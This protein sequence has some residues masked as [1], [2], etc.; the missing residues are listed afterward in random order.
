MMRD[1]DQL[2]STNVRAALAGCPF[3]TEIIYRPC[4]GS[5]NDLA[6]EKASAGVPEGL[7]VIADQQTAGRGRLGRRW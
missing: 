5:T 2:T 3:V 1:L 4:L 7:L 6:K